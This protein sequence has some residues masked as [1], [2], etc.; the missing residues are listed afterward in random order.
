[1]AG[2]ARPGLPGADHDRVEVLHIVH[3][4]HRA[5]PI[6]STGDRV[7]GRTRSR[8]RTRSR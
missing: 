8:P 3:T 1:V 7:R 6:I 4:L 5:T 2:D